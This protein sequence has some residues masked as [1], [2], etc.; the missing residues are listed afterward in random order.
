M[1][2]KKTA[3]KAT[4]AAKASN[5]LSKAAKARAKNNPNYWLEPMDLK[6][7]KAKMPLEAQETFQKL[8]DGDDHGFLVVL[9][10]AHNLPHKSNLG[11]LKGW[12]RPYKAIE[13]LEQ[14]H[15]CATKLE[16]L[17]DDMQ[18]V[19]YYWPFLPDHNP[20][21]ARPY[22]ERCITACPGLHELVIRLT[23]ARDYIEANREDLNNFMDT[24]GSPEQTF[25][26]D[27]FV[28]A[29]SI[30][31]PE[32]ALDIARAVFHEV[33]GS[34]PPLDWQISL[35]TRLRQGRA[36]VLT[37]R[38]KVYLDSYLDYMANPSKY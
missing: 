10:R 4:G 19:N 31:K 22:N 5:D 13:K 14:A 21:A 11:E 27:V 29:N 38:T 23:Q 20:D 30:G 17:I 33:T 2:E 25:F 24:Y 35:F 6:S 12:M 32:H 18:E 15:A 8:V 26:A 16:R 7:I 34:P 36:R 3:K 37:P 1:A 28:A 9:A